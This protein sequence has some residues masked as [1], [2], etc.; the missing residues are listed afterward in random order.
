MPKILT[1]SQQFALQQKIARKSI[2]EFQPMIKQALQAD[3]DKAAQMVQAL[4]VEQAA[5]NRAGFFT[6][7]RI[8][9]I[10]RTLYESTGGY[11]AMRY[12]KMFEKN[13]KAEEIDLDPLNILDEWLA[14]MLSY[15]VAIS[16]PKMYGIEN[17]TENEIARILATVIKIGRQNGLSQN[18]VN[19]LA[20]DALRDG[21]IN[22]ARSLLIA[23]TES[24]QALSA[25]AMGGVSLAGV[26][27]LKQWIAA[28]YPAKSG[29]PR[30]WHKDLDRLTDPDKKGVRIPVNQPFLVNTPDYG[31]IEMQYAHDAAGL[32]VNNCNCRCCTVYIA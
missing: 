5:N 18:E 20:I 29:K 15:W 16:G 13:K 9:N 11:T 31:I 3:F 30:L 12:Q 27:I 24:H 2:R 22:N 6:G 14:F 23:R 26:P 7:D 25:G 32:A 19:A 8:N 21:R 17:T 4:G 10:L 1:P 28:E